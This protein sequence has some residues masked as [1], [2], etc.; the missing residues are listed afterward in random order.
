ML[1]VDIDAGTISNLT[2]F[3]CYR[4]PACGTEIDSTGSLF[5]AANVVDDN[6]AANPKPLVVVTLCKKR[7]HATTRHVDEA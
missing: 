5:H 1:P 3:D 6:R 2:E 4:I 7:P